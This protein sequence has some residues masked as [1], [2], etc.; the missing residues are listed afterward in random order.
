VATSVVAARVL[1]TDSFSAYAAMV[2]V[3]GVLGTGVA[4]AVEQETARRVASAAD[5]SE[6]LRPPLMHSLVAVVVAALVV[7]VPLGWQEALLAHRAHTGQVLILLGVVGLHAAAV[8]RGLLA[9]THRRALLG[10]AICL[11]GV[12]PVLLG[13]TLAFLGV[14]GFLAFGI[15]TVV[16]SSSAVVVAVPALR[17]HRGARARR[18][19]DPAVRLAGLVAGN[20]FLTAN[21][22]AVPAVLRVHVDDLSSGVV[23]SLQIVVSLSRLSTLL[24]ANGVSVVV[25]S[26]ARDP[27]GSTLRVAAAGATAFGV[28]AAVATAALAP[29]LLPLVF[30]SGYSIGVGL[31][32]LGAVSV[33]FLNP[34]YVLTGVAAARGQGNLVAAA[35]GG[36][37]LA[38]A[39]VAAWPGP[40][41]AAGVLTGIAA[42]AAVPA[43][44]MAVALVR[45]RGAAGRSPLTTAADNLSESV[46]AEE[47]DRAQ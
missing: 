44:L 19:D 36:G 25:A 39:V 17:S 21:M 38:L 46:R 7:L 5:E 37:A 47:Q 3:L 33:L 32:G 2:S 28:L 4:G 18:A 23:A 22:V 1:G 30:G 10:L 26:A 35:W 15:G 9:G 27:R 20:L 29:V 31:A 42:S 40:T 24:V 16:G 14:D 11:T 8:A 41:S 45:P 34:A 13:S 6:A 12:L 43:A